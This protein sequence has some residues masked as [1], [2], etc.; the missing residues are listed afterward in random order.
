MSA[1]PDIAIALHLLETTTLEIGTDTVRLAGPRFEHRFDTLSPAT[2]EALRR[3]AKAPVAEADLSA[4]I[5]AGDGLTG[6]VRFEALK[7]QLSSLGTLGRS[8]LLDGAVLATLL[9]MASGPPVAGGKATADTSYVLSRFSSLSRDADR[10]QMTCPLASARLVFH[11][12]RVAALFATMTEARTLGDLAHRANLPE[13]AVAAL[14][15][16]ALHMQ[17]VVAVGDGLAAEDDIS[18]PLGA[19]EPHDLAFHARTRIGR[20]DNAYGGTFHLKGRV[21]PP[22]VI[23]PRPYPHDIALARPDMEKLRA[24]D[25]PFVDVVEARRS[26]RDYGPPISAETLGHFLF[27]AARVSE[28]LRLPSG[29]MDLSFRPYPGGGAIHEL[30]IYPLVHRCDGLAPGLYH[31]DPVSHA[32]GLVAQPGRATD[33][34]VQIAWTTADRKSEPQVAFTICARFQRLQWKYQTVA[35][36]VILKNTGVLYH[37]F[38][39]TAT[40]MGLAPCGL[41]GGTLDLFCQTAGLD[42][43]RESPVGEF[44]LGT[45]AASP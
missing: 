5:V 39:Q 25:P 30:E 12:A 9:P 8:V 33:R 42:P 1:D 20:H 14:I 4:D 45:R 23:E 40:A 37:A 6:L 44:M 24:T 38:Y 11:D 26:I 32:L 43:Y 15:D 3:L 19:W 17:A 22:P 36:S 18:T 16:M 29:E 28:V 7:F 27:R 35:Y 21:P 2:R 13:S 10:M 31:Y 34:L 41:G